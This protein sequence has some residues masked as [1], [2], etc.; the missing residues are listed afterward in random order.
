MNTK[1][2]YQF[3][4]ERVYARDPV[5]IPL[6]VQRSSGIT[7]TW[8]INEI[9]AELCRE[10]GSCPH[11]AQPTPPRTIYG[12]DSTELRDFES[13][14]YKQAAT[15]TETYVRRGRE[16][17]RAVRKT[18]PI[19][20]VAVASYPGPIGDETPERRRW[21][22]LVLDASRERWG[23]KVTSI[24][25]HEDEAHYHLHIVVHNHG[26]SVK[27][28]H[29]A[30]AMAM[31]LVG[32]TEELGAGEAYREGGRAAQNWYHNHVGT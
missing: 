3:W 29:F 7:K 17:R 27:P 20:L 1:P 16:H 24:I 30:H 28:L 4:S 14:L 22:E 12:L 6:K 5:T 15:F 9:V 23:G 25:A 13:S 32:P 11:V 26:S 21:Q 2:K 31:G 18:T 10:P 19:I 8:T